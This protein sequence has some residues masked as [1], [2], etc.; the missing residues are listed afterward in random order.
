MILGIG[1]EACVFLYAGLSGM[2]VMFG[3][4]LLR[5]FRK[6][7]PHNFRTVGVED[8]LFWTGASGYIFSRMYEATFGSI[9][10]FFLLGLGV[11]AGAGY[12]FLRAAAPPFLKVEKIFS[13]RKKSLEK[14]EK[15][16]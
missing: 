3:Y 15:S 13:A 9:R 14:L 16:R 4:E 6:L 8:L 11:G 5:C 2:T 10:W 12:L 1:T 7:V